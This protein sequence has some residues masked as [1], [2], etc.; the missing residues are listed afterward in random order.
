MRYWLHYAVIW[1][2]QRKGADFSAVS[3]MCLPGEEYWT[4]PI[5]CSPFFWAQT[6][7]PSSELSPHWLRAG[8]KGPMTH[9]SSVTVLP[10]DFLTVAPMEEPETVGG[11]VSRL[12]SGRKKQSPWLLLLPEGQLHHC[13]SWELGSWVPTLLSCLPLTW[14]PTH[15]RLFLR[16]LDMGFRHLKPT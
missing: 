4:A 7:S 13:S 12:G 5:P 2:H 1:E 11:H 3:E 16:W 9:T 14:S 10:Q 15:S 6:F 8:V